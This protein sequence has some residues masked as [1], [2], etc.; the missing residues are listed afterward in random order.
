MY[1]R[2]CV[3]MMTGRLGTLISQAVHQQ[4][5]F[6]GTS[7]ACDDSRSC[8]LVA[9][10][11]PFKISHTLSRH[12]FGRIKNGGPLLPELPMSSFLRALRSRRSMYRNPDC[13]FSC[14]IQRTCYCLGL[15]IQSK[16]GTEPTEATGSLC[17]PW[18]TTESSVS[19][20]KP[21]MG[22]EP[23]GKWKAKLIEQQL[24]TTS[25]LDLPPQNLCGFR[26]LPP[27][28]GRSLLLISYGSAQ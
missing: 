18:S 20:S 2:M 14:D 5:S 28:A 4:A 12:S 24:S 6:F 25:L 9:F 27:K 7:E 21:F 26:A 3:W 23:P 16:V 1:F 11:S 10:T 8:L 15:M 22:T 13:S 19:W 17:L